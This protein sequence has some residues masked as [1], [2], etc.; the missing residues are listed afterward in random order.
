M[1]KKFCVSG[2]SW[3]TS[4][5][6]IAAAGL[7]WF[8]IGLRGEAVLGVWSYD[9]VDIVSRNALLPQRSQDFEVAGFTVSKIVSKADRASNKQ[10][11]NGKK[12]EVS[13]S[14]TIEN[15]EE[16]CSVATDHLQ[17]QL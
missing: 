6:D 13:D 12:R 9:G 1:R 8:A 5:V 16:L 10:R 7:G 17:H 2:N 3:D 15:S 14:T 11:K 4:C